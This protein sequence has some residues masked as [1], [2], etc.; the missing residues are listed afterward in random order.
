MPFHTEIHF[1]IRHTEVRLSVLRQGGENIP[2]NEIENVHGHQ[3][4]QDVC[5]YQ[6][7]GLLVFSFILS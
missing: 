3:H 7:P 4:K 6:P 5:E 1:R 2:I